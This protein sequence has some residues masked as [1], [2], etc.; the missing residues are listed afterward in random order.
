MRR[1]SGR[2]AGLTGYLGA[3]TAT[4]VRMNDPWFFFPIVIGILVWA[5]LYPR[6]EQLRAMIP[7][8]R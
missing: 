7:I 6:D 4:M 1:R 5:A 2:L 3:A 8:P